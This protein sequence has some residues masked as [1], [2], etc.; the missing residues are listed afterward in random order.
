V[1]LIAAVSMSSSETLPKHDA[2]QVAT[3]AVLQPSEEMPEGARKVQG[4]EFNGRAEKEVTVSELLIGMTNMGFQ[5]SALADAVRIINNMV[6]PTA[7][8]RTADFDQEKMERSRNRRQ[9]HYIS[10]IH[11]KYDLVRPKRDF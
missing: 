3:D 11:V 10:G 2:P 9:D 7:M 8:K 5:A 6:C 4:F 1:F